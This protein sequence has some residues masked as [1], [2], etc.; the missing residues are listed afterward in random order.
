MFEGPSQ[1]VV[2]LLVLELFYLCNF[3]TTDNFVTTEAHMYHMRQLL[4][5]CIY[6]TYTPI[7]ISNLSD[8][9]HD[10][11]IKLE[12]DSQENIRIYGPFA[13]LIFTEMCSSSLKDFI[14]ETERGLINKDG[15]KQLLGRFLFEITDALAFMH[16]Q[17]VIHH[18]I[19]PDNI[20]ISDDLHIRI[21][22]FGISRHV[23]Q[24][25]EVFG[26]ILFVPPEV[27]PGLPD[28]VDPPHPSSKDA[29]A[30]GV[31][32]YLMLREAGG[33]KSTTY[34]SDTWFSI[35]GDKECM[36]EISEDDK[37]GL[38][39]KE[40][41]H[42]LGSE[43]MRLVSGML[44]MDWKQRKSIQNVRQKLLGFLR[45]P[46]ELFAPSDDVAED[47]NDGQLAPPVPP[48]RIEFQPRHWLLSACAW[49]LRLTPLLLL[50]ALVI[51]R[52]VVESDDEDVQK[53]QNEFRRMVAA[54]TAAMVS[55]S[56]V[57]SIIS[58]GLVR[59]KQT[60]AL[61]YFLIILVII[62][63]FLLGLLY[64][65]S[66]AR[67][68]G[69]LF[70]LYAISQFFTTWSVHTTDD[71]ASLQDLSN[72]QSKY[73]NAKL[74]ENLTR[75]ELFGLITSTLLF[76][77]GLL[78]AGITVVKG[79]PTDPWEV[80]FLAAICWL[81]NLPRY[82]A[83]F[84]LVRAMTN[85]VNLCQRLSYKTLLRQVL[86][87]IN[88][89]LL[90]SLLAVQQPVWSVFETIAV[91]LIRAGQILIGCAVCASCCGDGRDDDG[92]CLSWILLCF[93]ASLC[94]I[95]I[96]LLRLSSKLSI[97]CS[98]FYISMLAYDVVLGGGDNSC[99]ALVARLRSYGAESD[100][101]VKCLLFLANKSISSSNNA[102]FC[103][104]LGCLSALI[105]A[106]IDEQ[107]A[108]YGYLAGYLACSTVLEMQSSTWHWFVAVLGSEDVVCPEVDA[109]RTLLHMS[110]RFLL[111]AYILLILDADDEHNAR[112]TPYHQRQLQKGRGKADEA[113]K[114]HRKKRQRN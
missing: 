80:I 36:W 29:F 85:A 24:H 74:L 6:Q 57:A 77:L 15:G 30:M 54:T 5:I 111:D 78:Y 37:E 47:M 82:L 50:I 93:G 20:L 88:S 31:T 46:D 90:W 112:G 108:L 28:E 81:V 44:K 110:L 113:G 51:W 12:T 86:E 23:N 94:Y 98:K 48:A 92:N 95:G 13:L 49:V 16:N 8:D 102:N 59:M 41:S 34:H 9:G 45:D 39:A 70:I 63:T 64:V 73:C 105:A 89:I 43:A 17:D 76:Q 101:S 3:V 62:S 55:S 60:V 103:I 109:R 87:N 75:F 2:D 40:L 22:D 71:F 84:S 11:K 18:D 69:A 53:G 52:F 4:L 56:V 14:K 97:Y 1:S 66:D 100:L 114:Q 91:S 35:A 21:T 96:H 58:V 7:W 106:A 19:K 104:L 65:N 68:V 27:M 10:R 67:I 26:T 33:D 32:A 38:L 99:W 72:T 107:A 79:L 25:E 42:L 83:H 61:R